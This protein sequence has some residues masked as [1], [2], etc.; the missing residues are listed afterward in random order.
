MTKPVVA[1][2]EPQGVQLEKGREYYFCCC[3]RSRNQPF[4][5]GSHEGTG[6]EP[7]AFEASET[8]EAW[9]CNCK[10]SSNS[11]YCDGSHQQVPESAVGQEFALDREG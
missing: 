7:M 5:D 1:A 2:L 11:P 6:I 10:Q 8:G 3:G 4:C 9:L